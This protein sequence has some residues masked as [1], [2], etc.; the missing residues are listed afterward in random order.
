M[1][2]CV[3]PLL[4][5]G[6]IGPVR[7][8]CRTGEETPVRSSPSP[9]GKS[10]TTDG[11]LDV[12]LGRLARAAAGG[13]TGA[14]TALVTALSPLL[15]RLALRLV[16]DED[17]AA[18]VVQQTVVKLWRALPRVADPVAIRSFAFAT[19][20][21]VAAD[22]ARAAALRRTSRLP[23]TDDAGAALAAQLTSDAPDAA[24]LVQSAQARAL[25]HAALDAL[26]DEHRL[27][28]LLCEVDGVSYDDAACALGI[29]PGTVASRLSR[30]RVQLARKVR[31]LSASPKPRASFWPWS[32]R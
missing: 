10:P 18:D 31:A 3:L 25:V 21:H 15:W 1:T 5:P 20:R 26:P 30:A 29:K 28:L 22:E 32:R 16:D 13:D 2:T 19:L 8:W 12:R 17:H 7:S 23:A 14:F 11:D 24:S 9:A 4:P 27:V 6:P